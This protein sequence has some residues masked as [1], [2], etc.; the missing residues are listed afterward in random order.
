MNANRLIGKYIGDNPGPMLICLGGIHGNELAGVLALERM[1]RM[2]E[3]EPTHNPNWNYEGSLIGVIGNLKAYSEKR[4]YVKEDLNRQWAD[5]N[6]RR[7]MTTDPLTLRDEEKDVREIIELVREV[8][9]DINPTE[10]VVLD[11]HTTSSTGGIFSIVSDSAESLL[12][13][14]ELHAPVITGMHEGLHGTTLDYFRT[15]NFDRDTTAVVFESGQHDEELSINR[16]IACITNC[17]RTIGSVNEDHIENKHDSLLIEHSSTLPEVAKLVDKYDIEQ[18]ENFK[19][20]PGFKN[21]QRIEKGELLAMS[22]NS[23]ITSPSSGMILMP[24]YQEQGEDG[25]FLI[26]PFEPNATNC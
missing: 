3:I 12:I 15:D 6:V 18:G 25:F 7:I 2:L 20:L 1:F 9:D 8:I 11:L 17:M 23:E 14:I 5:D 10:I 19:M 22:G 26:E 13:A 16:A 4:R 21:F 24:L